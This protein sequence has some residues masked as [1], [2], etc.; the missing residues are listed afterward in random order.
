MKIEGHKISPAFSKEINKYVLIVSK[1]VESLEITA[2]PENEEAT[3]TVEG[4][5]NLIMGLN[6]ITVKVTAKDGEPVMEYIINVTKTENMEI[7]N[8]DLKELTFKN[9]DLKLMFDPD[10]IEYTI[11]VGENVE[12]IELLAKAVNS[13]ATIT[14]TGNEKIKFGQN[15]ITIKVLA[16]DGITEKIYTIIVNKEKGYVTAMIGGGVDMEEDTYVI[17]KVLVGAIAGFT[18]TTGA[19]TYFMTESYLKYAKKLKELRGAKPAKVE[20]KH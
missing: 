14:I 20:S 10:I 17:N 13:K 3:V 8:A 12:Q 16:E 6:K 9:I 5:K 1:D 18:V 4:N 15:V 2:V 19:V 11:D 7:A